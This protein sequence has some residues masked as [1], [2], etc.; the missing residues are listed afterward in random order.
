MIAGIIDA[1]E[2]AHGND[3]IPLPR[4]QLIV[5]INVTLNEDES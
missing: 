1:C 5:L 3:D 2:K 4:I